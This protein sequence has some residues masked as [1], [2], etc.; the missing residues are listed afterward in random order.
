M[1]TWFVSWIEKLGPNL[2]LT[3]LTMQKKKP[4]YRKLKN[5]WIQ[6]QRET[7]I[8]SCD[9]EPTR[10]CPF[11]GQSRRGYTLTAIN[12]RK[13]QIL[14]LNNNENEEKEFDDRDERMNTNLQ[15][16]IRPMAS[17]C[18]SLEA[19]RCSLLSTPTLW[20]P[21][22]YSIYLFIKEKDTCFKTIFQNHLRMVVSKMVF[23]KPS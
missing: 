14:V 9:L 21:R 3:L 5:R 8:I 22:L 13:N 12:N 4:W 6:R 15:L 2:S 20:N 23:A 18:H 7:K 10:G 11:V 17:G 16:C 1:I 19:A